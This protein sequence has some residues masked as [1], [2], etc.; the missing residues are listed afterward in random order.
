MS[1]KL[2]K[3]ISGSSRLEVPADLKERILSEIRSLSERQLRMRIRLA[4]AG[5]F[6]SL[7]MAF[8]SIFNAS[9]GFIKSD[10]WQVL[11]LLFTDLSVIARNWQEFLF[12]LE[13]TFPLGLVLMVLIPV[14]TLLISLVYYFDNSQ[15]NNVKNRH[16][17]A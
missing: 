11:S 16:R 14:F 3:F 6:L 9:R 2:K 7:I 15:H 8:S 5:I 4:Y 17:H 1:N 13:E 12:S 10:F